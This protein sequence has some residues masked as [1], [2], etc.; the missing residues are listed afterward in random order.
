MS[1]DPTFTARAS[2]VNTGDLYKVFT[3][4][5]GKQGIL[6][7]QLNPSAE[8]PRLGTAVAAGYDL[9]TPSFVGFNPGER[10]VIKLG[11]ALAL[12]SDLHG[13]IE[14][15]SSLAL[16]GMVVLTGVID[17]DYRGELMVIMQNFG[18]QYFEFVPGDR[19]A[20]L[21]LRQT[22]HRSFVPVDTLEDT[23]RGVGGF[24]STGQ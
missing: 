12:P 5:Y 6:F 21:V 8:I 17:A 7:K 11:F 1:T 14:S 23:D 20:Q 10:K 18:S 2:T 3:A 9:A 4:P 16:K 24:G 22:V 15:R 13:R 19:V